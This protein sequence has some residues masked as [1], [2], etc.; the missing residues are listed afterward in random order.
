MCISGIYALTNNV[1]VSSEHILTTSA[2]NIELKEYLIDSSKNEK[3]FNGENIVIF[4]G[5]SI[6]LV[7]KVINLGANCYIRA[8]LNIEIDNDIINNIDDSILGISDKW[9]K[10]GDYYYYDSIIN[11]GEAVEI[12]NSVNFPNNLPEIYQ[13]KNIRV[14]IVAEAIQSKNFNPDYTLQDPWNN[15]KIEK[16]VDNTYKVSQENNI[17]SIT[18]IKYANNAEKYIEVSENFFGNLNEIV[19]GDNIE[20]V[21]KIKNKTETTTE[22][23]YSIEVSE[24]INDAEKELLEKCNLT[25]IKNDTETIYSDSLLNYKNNSL[26]KFNPKEEAT[27]K[28][29][30]SV[31]EEL[32]NKFSELKTKFRWNFSVQYE[33]ENIQ[34]EEEKP[35][36][37]T[38]DEPKEDNLD[39]V[40]KNITNSPKTGDFK[41]DLSLTIFFISAIVLIIVL[42]LENRIKKNI[43]KN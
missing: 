2:V 15:V 34:N 24:N 25:V 1:I 13:G 20:E 7:P 36:E 10:Y 43:D 33:D 9:K 8:K 37:K 19:P 31:P 26:G 40:I 39:K 14:K 12:F 27:I 6:P 16:C 5:S 3:Q 28:F 22:Y 21:I 23:F 32:D 29:I 41:F 18:E 38:E 17:S 30:I 11:S 4:P 42:F 35:E